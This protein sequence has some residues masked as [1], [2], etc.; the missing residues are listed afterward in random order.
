M[1]TLTVSELAESL[2]TDAR[3]TRRFL[4][5]ITPK[6]AQPGK[7]ARWSIEKKSL[8]S[9]KKQFATYLEARAAKE[10]SDTDA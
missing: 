10:E 4:R 5:S 1:T 8:T 9:L 7:G 3:T 2:E 6:D